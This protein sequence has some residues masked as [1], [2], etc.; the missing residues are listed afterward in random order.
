[1]NILRVIKSH[2]LKENHKTK[3]L[4]LVLIKQL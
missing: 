1:M 2:K 4:N 3:A